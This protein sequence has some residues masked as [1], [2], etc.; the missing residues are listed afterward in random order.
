MKN[1][2]YYIAG[3]FCASGMGFNYCERDVIVLEVKALDYKDAEE[4]VK[5]FCN[6]YYGVQEQKDMWYGIV[7]Y[8]WTYQQLYESELRRYK[9]KA[10]DPNCK[11]YKYYTLKSAK[12]Y[13]APKIT[14]TQYKNP[15]DYPVRETR[16]IKEF[17][18]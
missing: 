11:E 8:N 10:N 1:T 4:E 9:S 2:F 12:L 7:A 16:V 5:K 18:S 17:F 6:M 13:T 14:I 15:E 3:R